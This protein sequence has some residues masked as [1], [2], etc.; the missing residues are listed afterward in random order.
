MS[1]IR[2]RII[3]RRVK[4]PRLE[5]WGNEI[6]V[7]LPGNVDPWKVIR[8]NGPWLAR[9]I[10]L[11]RRAVE[12]SKRIELVPRTRRKFRSLVERAAR[13]YAEELG[14]EVNR[15]FVRRIRSAWGSCSGKR[16]IAVSAMA[17]R[18]P[19]RLIR[20]IVYHEVCHLLRWRH[21][22]EF[23]DLMRSKFPDCDYLDLQLQAY[24]I[25]LKEQEER[26]EC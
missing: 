16:N 1:G 13:E 3:R 8:E 20:Y 12:L 5:I 15:V 21:D 10:E 7:I 11:M 26:G 9:Q 19:E 4:H 17:Q 24:W 23:E 2:Y 22:R 6:R 18:L 14:V 25:K